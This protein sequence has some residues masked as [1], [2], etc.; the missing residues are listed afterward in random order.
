MA[1]TTSTPSA[2]PVRSQSA[3][4]VEDH[5]HQRRPSTAGPHPRARSVANPLHPSPK[6]W[7]SATDLAPEAEGAAQPPCSGPVRRRG[8]RPHGAGDAG[9]RAARRGPPVTRAERGGA[10]GRVR[11]RQ[12]LGLALAVAV[13]AAAGGLGA[14]SWGGL[15]PGETP[16]AG[17][18]TLY[19][20]PSRERSLVEEGRTVAEWTYAG[21][22]A[23]QGLERM[24]IS[25][26]FVVGGRFAPDVVRSIV[27][28]PKPHVFSLRSIS[29]GGAG[30][31]RDGG[32]D[33]APR[34]TTAPRGCSSSSTR[35]GPGPSSCCSVP[36]KPP[37]GPEPLGR[38]GV[39]GPQARC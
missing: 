37:G 33:R 6:Q 16:R 29:N 36:D 30:R 20:R 2:R 11:A 17:V 8:P 18:E 23:P 9:A 13:L 12:A 26:G 15:T 14:E 28:Y 3:R 34:S 19:G 39:V 21:E 1:A 24:V 32:S 10:R 7:R 4:P 25:F 22:R 31:G 27:L 35:P 38:A 5:T